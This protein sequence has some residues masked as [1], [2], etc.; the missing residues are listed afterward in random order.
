MS[1]VHSGG[2][3]LAKEPVTYRS[4][5]RVRTVLAHR[6]PDGVPYCAIRKTQV[7][8]FA[9]YVITD[10]SLENL[11]QFRDLLRVGQV[12]IPCCVRPQRLAETRAS[13][14]GGGS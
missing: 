12:L 7:V 4:R 8:K 13:E 3:G 2:E 9:N 6:E 5:E 1:G 14:N 10:R 11:G